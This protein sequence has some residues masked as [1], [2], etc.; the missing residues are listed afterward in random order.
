[1][2]DLDE[3]R[4]VLSDGLGF[5]EA[6][7]FKEPEINVKQDE[8]L[9]GVLKMVYIS[10]T[11]SRQIRVSFSQGK[12]KFSAAIIMSIG[13]PSGASFFVED[14]I[15]EKLPD[16]QLPFL[17]DGVVIDEEDLLRRSCIAYKKLLEGP[18]HATVTGKEWDAVPFNWGGYR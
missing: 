9:G 5:L 18:L 2:M 4:Q 7:G 15:D 10:T 1:M 3:A 14:W 6:L 11:V 12:G 16:F 17:G 8:L 13:M